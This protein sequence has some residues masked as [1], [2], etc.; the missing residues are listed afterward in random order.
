MPFYR[1]GGAMCHLN[2]GGKARK[3][4]PKPCCATITIEGKPDL[5]RGI[6]GFLCDWETGPGTTCDRPLCTDHAT[7][8]GR[9][10]HLCPEH[11]AKRAQREPQLF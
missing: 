8:V 4:P 2:L 1:I 7:E 9:N 11:A 3:R 6:S 10:R 5:C